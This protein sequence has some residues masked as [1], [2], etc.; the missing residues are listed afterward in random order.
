MISFVLSIYG[1]VS[2][3]IGILIG[4]PDRIEALRPIQ[5]AVNEIPLFPTLLGVIAALGGSMTRPRSWLAILSGSIGALLAARP[6]LA[7][8]A[9]S[10][11]MHSAM[12]AGLGRD[13]EAC[14]PAAAK[15]RLPKATWSLS[16]LTGAI[17]HALE[18]ERLDDV[19]YATR[20]GQDLKLNIYQP[21]V[22]IANKEKSPAIIVIHGGGWRNG[23]PGG[24]FAAHNRYFASQG[25][26]IFDVEYRLSGVAKWPAQL[27]D[28]QAAVEW[29]IA[30]AADYHIDPQ[31]I[32]LLGRSAGAHLALMAAYCGQNAI[33][34]VVSI[35]GPTELRWPDLEADSAILELVGGTFEELPQAYENATPLN[36]VCDGLPPTLIIEGGMDTIVPYHHGDALVGRLSLTDTPFVLLRVPWSRHGFDAV[37]SGLGAQLTYYHLDRFLAWSLY[38]KS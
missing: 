19:V 11:D 32:A 5:I 1:L 20:D 21:I 4:L 8:R 23:E 26:T 2:V 13:Y 35:Y 14:I 28:V 33:R 24:W 12:R 38:G 29:V 30:H 18:T 37:L 31:R 7:Y 36:F 25:Y 15:A 9:A 10:T 17:E 6:L 22:P 27:E 34:S 16:N 3:G